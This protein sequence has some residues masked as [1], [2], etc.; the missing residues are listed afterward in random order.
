VSQ[1]CKSIR[2][3]LERIERRKVKR[4]LKAAF[5]RKARPARVVERE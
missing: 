4:R 3:L 1:P 2:E 5:R